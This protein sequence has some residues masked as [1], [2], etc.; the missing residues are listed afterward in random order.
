MFSIVVSG[1]RARGER[2]RID[3]RAERIN[4]SQHLTCTAVELNNRA[5]KTWD[6]DDIVCQH[7]MEHRLPSAHVV[8]R[9]RLQICRQVPLLNQCAPFPVQSYFMPDLRVEGVRVVA[10][11]ESHEHVLAI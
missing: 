11:L 8:N 7:G 2:M 6:V 5:T 10:C 1:Q 3:S 9:I 4:L